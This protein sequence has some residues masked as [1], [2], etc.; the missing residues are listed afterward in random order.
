[1]DEFDFFLKIVSVQ[2]SLRAPRLI[3]RDLEINSR[4]LTSMALRRLEV[5]IIGKQIQG[6]TTDLLLNVD[7]SLIIIDIIDKSTLINEIIVKKAIK[8]I[9]KKVI[10]QFQDLL[11]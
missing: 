7:F 11:Y 6:L 4:V 3:S 2:A 9:T 5:V 10:K 8:K 1:M